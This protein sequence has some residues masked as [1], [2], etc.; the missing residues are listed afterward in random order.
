MD[1]L[2]GEN[3]LGRKYRRGPGWEER[4]GEDRAGC[5][6]RIREDWGERTVEDRVG[7]KT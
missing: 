2:G 6:E 7:R 1:R 5:E 3:R 4:I